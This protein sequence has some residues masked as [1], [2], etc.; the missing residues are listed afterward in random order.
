MRKGILSLRIHQADVPGLIAAQ[1]LT[2]F[3]FRS[4]KHCS[5]A[6][7]KSLTGNR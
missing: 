3:D 2:I 7:Q 4:I 6:N 5:F 1:G